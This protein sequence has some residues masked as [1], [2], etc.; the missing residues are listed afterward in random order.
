VSA[1]H[2]QFCILNKQYT[3]KEYNELV[4]KIREHMAKMP[5][6]NSTGHEYRYGEFFPPEFAPYSYSETIAQEYFPLSKEE[7]LA[8]GYT[9][10]DNEKRTYSITMKLENIPDSIKDVEDSITKE[11]VECAHHGDCE[12]ACNG[13]FRITSDELQFLRKMK[14]PLPRLC[15]H[16]RHYERIVFRNSFHL[17][18]RK[19]MNFGCLNEFET[20]YAPDCPEIVYCEQCYQQETA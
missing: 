1:H 18:H 11:V 20:S 2:K 6:I 17:Y 8:K 16:C 10:R 5:Y 15:P 4:P 3:E 9:W 12:H 7:S 14:L 13:A 19:C